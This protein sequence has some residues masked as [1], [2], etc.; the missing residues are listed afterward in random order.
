LP[1]LGWPLMR[2]PTTLASRRMMVPTAQESPP[3]GWA[4]LA[5]SAAMIS[6]PDRVSSSS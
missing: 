2:S 5:A 6:S 1:G 3:P 4:C